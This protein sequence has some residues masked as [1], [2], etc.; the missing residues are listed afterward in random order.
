MRGCLGNGSGSWLR[1]WICSIRKRRSEKQEKRMSIKLGIYDL[2][3]YTIPGLLYLYI[4]NEA[5]KIFGL[6]YFT[7]DQF[8][9]NLAYTLVVVIAAYLVC[10]LLDYF[11]YLIGYRILFRKKMSRIVHAAIKENYPELDIRFE[12]KD[13]DILYKILGQRN[14]ELHQYIDRYE[15]D[16]IM[17]RNAGFGLLLYTL[18]LVCNIV[19]NGNVWPGILGPIISLVLCMI[20]FRQSRIF[21]RWFYNAIFLS[22]LEYGN[23]LK[24]IL[25]Y[26]TKM[27]S[28]GAEDEKELQKKKDG[29]K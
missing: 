8:K 1:G 22:S 17:L 10:H 25:A 4:F 26:E 3:A 24:N 20:A 18:I 5:L 9:D 13:W 2:F 6:P 29:K 15:A 14:I 21:H 16:A 19:F 27:R 28:R 11:G 12:A 7:I 23:S